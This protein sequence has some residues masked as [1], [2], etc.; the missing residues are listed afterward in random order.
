MREVAFA[1]RQRESPPTRLH[2]T[3]Q[4]MFGVL[5][6]VRHGLIRALLPARRHPSSPHRLP[7]WWVRI[8]GWRSRWLLSRAASRARCAGGDV[9]RSDRVFR[10][11]GLRWHH[12]AIARDL[13]RFAAHVSALNCSGASAEALGDLQNIFGFFHDNIWNTYNSLEREVLFPWL[14]EGG[15]KGSGFADIRRA[16]DAFN[17]ERDRIDIGARAVRA[18]LTALARKGSL[19]S[20]TLRNPKVCSMEMRKLVSDVNV[21]LTDSERLHKTEQDILF[22]Y[23]SR[24]FTKDDQ[25]RITYKIINMMDKSLAKLNLVSFHEALKTT[26]ATRADWKNYEREVPTPVRLY[27]W[28]WKGRLWDPSPLARLDSTVTNSES[29]LRDKHSDV[30]NTVNIAKTPS[31][32]R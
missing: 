3:L 28:V 15:E 10:L 5:A 17:S 16:I 13:R 11:N 22:P 14:C 26:T 30:K 27:L 19:Q 2:T 25:I 20:A 31:E 7:P 9:K 18:K 24:Q 8:R 23:I 29:I 32:N 12:M 1:S 4:G 6:P 21:L